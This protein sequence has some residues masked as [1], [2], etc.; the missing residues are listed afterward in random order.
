MASKGE[1]HAHPARVDRCSLVRG[2]ID[3]HEGAGLEAAPDAGDK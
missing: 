2:E 1:G 3:Y